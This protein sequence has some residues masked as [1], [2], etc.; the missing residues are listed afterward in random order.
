M[1]LSNFWIIAAPRAAKCPQ[2]ARRRRKIG[3]ARAIEVGGDAHGGH[4]VWIVDGE[5]SETRRSLDSAFF[6]RS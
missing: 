1:L 5:N 2:S 3:H 4:H 6:D